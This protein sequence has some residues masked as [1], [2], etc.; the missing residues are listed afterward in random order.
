METKESHKKDAHV[1][2]EEK[3]KASCAQEEGVDEGYLECCIHAHN[4]VR[5]LL[6]V[7]TVGWL[8]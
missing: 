3:T 2:R 6:D 4:N 5:P 7:W 8:S 1:L